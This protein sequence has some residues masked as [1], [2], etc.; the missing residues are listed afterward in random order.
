MPDITSG[1]QVA[2]EKN[3]RIRRRKLEIIILRL[4]A[5]VMEAENEVE[6]KQY[7]LSETAKELVAREAELAVL[8]QEAS[9]G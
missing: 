1:G 5:Q 9:N 2:N 7:S 8:A 6:A 3:T 4:R